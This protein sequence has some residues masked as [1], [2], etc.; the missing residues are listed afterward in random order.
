MAIATILFP[1]D[2]LLPSAAHEQFREEVDAV[3]ARPELN[4][5]LFNFDDY[6]NGC[7]LRLS[8][9][10][11]PP[12]DL[13]IYR[14]WMMTPVQYEHFH[15]GLKEMGLRPLVTPQNYEC[16]H[17]FPAVANLIERMTPRFLTAP[18]RDGSIRIDVRA[19]NANFDRFMVKDYVK[20]LKGTSFPRAIRTPLAQHELDRLIDRF[21]RERGELFTGG[22]VLKE[23]VDL[24]R[25]EG[26]ANEWRQFVCDGASIAVNR[27]SGQP[28][29]APSPPPALLSAMEELPSP[30]YTV[31]Y[32]ELG[33]GSWVIIETGDGQVSGLAVSSGAGEFYGALVVALKAN[34]PKE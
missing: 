33:D 14:G 5:A 19:V 20:S 1:R 34:A 10:S 27:N 11:A 26:A 12:D 4:V 24:K 2:Y 25:Y 30:F 8:G 21:V 32:A 7:P 6:L 16:L 22:I 17:C 23:Y 3:R 18:L 29:S 15:T 31:D 9:P 28:A 13:V